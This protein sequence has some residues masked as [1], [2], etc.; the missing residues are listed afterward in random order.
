MGESAQG[1]ADYVREQVAGQ[2]A[3]LRH[4]LRH[5][6]PVAAL[7]RT[8]RRGHGR[9]RL[10]GLVPRRLPQHARTVVRRPLQAVRLRHHD[11]RQPQSAQRQ[12][13]QGLLVH[14]RAVAAAARPGRDRPRD[15]RHAD[16]SAC[17]SSEALADRP[18]RLLPGRSR[19][20]LHPRRGRAEPARP[21]DTE[22]H[23]LAAARRG[24]VGR[25][26]GPG[27]R[28][29][30]GRRGLRSARRARS[31]FHQRA[32]PRVQSRAAHRLRGDHRAGRSRA[33]RT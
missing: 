12:R 28:G 21:A 6:A 19:R 30:Q 3:G 22:D 27:R 29:V 25:L 31:R 24:R 8:V 15:G 11:H 5:A 20:G 23:L 16:P 32:Q 18:H 13:H 9:R 4:R 10:Q 33:A 7:R 17:R 14:R 1:L 2:A 26:P